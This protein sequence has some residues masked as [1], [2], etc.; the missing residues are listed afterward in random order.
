MT[1]IQEIEQNERQRKK[2]SKSNRRINWAANIICIIFE[3]IGQ[4]FSG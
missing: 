4:C 2:A 1:E 3:F